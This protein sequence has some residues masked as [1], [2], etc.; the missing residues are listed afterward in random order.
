MQCV[1]S[2][3]YIVPNL[4]ELYPEVVN[5]YLHGVQNLNVD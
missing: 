4:L 1:W 2:L 5:V 3:L